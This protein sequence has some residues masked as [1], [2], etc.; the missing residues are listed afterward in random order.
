MSPVERY[1][2]SFCGKAN[3]QVVRLSVGPDNV[4]SCNERVELF[5]EMLE[6]IAEKAPQQPQLW[7]ISARPV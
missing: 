6:E 1:H 4:S 3:D 7:S 5:Q 2:C